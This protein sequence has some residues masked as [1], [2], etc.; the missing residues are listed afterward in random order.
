[1]DIN[2]PKCH[3]DSIELYDY[4]LT[5]DSHIIMYFECDECHTAFE[6]YCTL[7]PITIIESK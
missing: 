2:C 4:E 7:T 6:V 5:D 3:K 1:M